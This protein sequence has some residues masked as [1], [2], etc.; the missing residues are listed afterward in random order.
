ML[1]PKDAI[2][3]E[4]KSVTNLKDHVALES[5]AF[6][7]EYKKEKIPVGP[8][9]TVFLFATNAIMSE[10]EDKVVKGN[11]MII[12]NQRLEIAFTSLFE[13]FLQPQVS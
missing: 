8:R 6:E 1:F 13:P 2:R 10:K 9:K 4:S 5:N 3:S 11:C 7:Y 12:N